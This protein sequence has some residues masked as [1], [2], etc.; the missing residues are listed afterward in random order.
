M[1]RAT[2]RTLSPARLYTRALAQVAPRLQL[3]K[4]VKELI[5][6]MRTPEGVG[7]ASVTG[8]DDLFGWAPPRVA[9]CT[10]WRCSGRYNTSG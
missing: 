7:L 1:R 2:L 4:S 8:A 6:S 10:G 9:A 5:G 3:E